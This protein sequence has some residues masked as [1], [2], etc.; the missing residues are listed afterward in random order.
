MSF[1]RE[2]PSLCAFTAEADVQSGVEREHGT[3]KPTACVLFATF[4]HRGTLKGGNETK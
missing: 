2:I 3:G 1:C 4:Q